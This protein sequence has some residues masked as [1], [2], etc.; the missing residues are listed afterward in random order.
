MLIRMLTSI[1]RLKSYSTSF[2]RNLFVSI[3]ISPSFTKA[4]HFLYVCSDS[5]NTKYY[6]NKNTIYAMAPTKKDNLKTSASKVEHDKSESEVS[7]NAKS[8]ETKA[9]TKSKRE[10]KADN[11]N[12]ESTSKKRG[13]GNNEKES[14]SKKSKVESP[15]IDTEPVDFSV[16]DKTTANGEKWNFKISSWNVAGIRAWVK[17]NGHKYIN[18]ENP[19]ILCLQEVKCTK[20]M[21]PHE[22]KISGYTTYFLPAEKK[23][24]S[25]VALYSK[26]KPL[27]VTYGLGKK[28]LDNEG[29]LITAEYEK[30]YLVATYVPNAGQ[31]LKTL[32]KRMQWDKEFQLYLKKLDEKKPVI[33]TGDLN[34]AHEPIDLANPKTNT[35]SAG[36]TQEERDGMTA[37]L[38]L[39]F[40][41]TFRHLYPEKNRSLY[42]L[43]IHGKCK[44]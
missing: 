10:A 25:G 9:T 30:F 7:P 43:D 40:V 17:K 20:D 26:Q 34:V 18:E 3:K 21:L 27:E 5:R 4:R 38:K 12:E 23:G 32:P 37:M 1:T 13:R 8:T 35:K 6:L 31:G 19:D 15:V 28:E 41:D 44:I 33:L 11:E 24:Y 16:C 14:A 36:F 39:G 22:V 2:I 42:L 29:R